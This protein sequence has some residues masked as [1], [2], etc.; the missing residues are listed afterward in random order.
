MRTTLAFILKSVGFILVIVA[1]VTAIN[2][3]FD[4]DLALG[5]YGTRTPLPDDWITVPMFLICSAIFIGFGFLIGS[6]KLKRFFQARP[7][8]KWGLWIFIVAAGIFLWYFGRYW[9]TGGKLQWAAENNESEIIAEMISEGGNKQED[10]NDA[11]KRAIFNRNR[12][13]VLVL[14]KGGADLNQSEKSC[15]LA[16]AARNGGTEIV[17]DLIKAGAKV[18]ECKNDNLLT[19]VIDYA[20]TD[21]EDK[22][23]SLLILLINSGADPGMMDS[24]GLTAL[25]IAKG[26]GLQKIVTIL[27]PLTKPSE[28]NVPVD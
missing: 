4:L 6:E 16:F 3:A 9:N 2:I 22:V 10:L 21:G 26:R 1:V 20:M 13:S 5:S 15:L 11:L 28:I 7:R 27:Q 25:D 24:N 19:A 18:S 8:L 17:T 23:V 12:E 14:A